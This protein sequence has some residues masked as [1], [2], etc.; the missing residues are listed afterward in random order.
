MPDCLI[1]SAGPDDL[2]DMAAVYVRAFPE[3]I[4]HFFGEQ[5]PPTQ[6]LA[7][8]FAVVLDAEPAAA[9][10]AVCGGQVIAYCLAPARLSR[11]WRH[12]VCSGQWARLL[13]RAVLGKYRLSAG[14]LKR[15]A[16]NALATWRAHREPVVRC[17]ACILSL[18]VDP[19]WQG[20]GL[21]RQ[22]LEQ[23]LKRLDTASI[24]CVRLEVRPDN[25]AARHLYESVGF[26][27]VG[28]TQDSQ[29]PWLIMVRDTRGGRNGQA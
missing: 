23:A 21:G 7:D 20:R 9:T 2:P 17:D 16:A 12:A 29:G 14:A 28:E 18:A 4:I 6:A 26:R 15:L 5:S 13:G 22:I 24:P 11:V 3:S 19:Q 27:A 8:L 10:V 1:R 25:T